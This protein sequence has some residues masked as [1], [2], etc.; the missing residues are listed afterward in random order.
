MANASRKRAALIDAPARSIV[1]IAM[2]LLV[3]LVAGTLVV[4]VGPAGAANSSYGAYK[5]YILFVTLPFISLIAI[6]I[7]SVAAV[8]RI[9]PHREQQA[10]TDG[11]AL[12]AELDAVLATKP[13][14][15]LTVVG[16]GLAVVFGLAL[17]V[18]ALEFATTTVNLSVVSFDIIC[19]LIVGIP[20]A[21]TLS[22]ALRRRTSRR[23][24]NSTMG[25][26]VPVI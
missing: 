7:L 16:V 9:K 18:V 19:L 1:W 23:R 13:Y 24:I 26:D 5:G 25:N 8:R 4:V 10:S 20:A 21:G 22:V 2:W 15:V 12:Q 3:G 14:V 6:V 11:I 17:V